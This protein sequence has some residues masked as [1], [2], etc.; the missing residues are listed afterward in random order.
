MKYVLTAACA[1]V[2]A[3]LIAPL[4]L[5][6]RPAP[7]PRTRF[8]EQ[9]ETFQHAA[10]VDARWKEKRGHAF[11]LHDREESVPEEDPRW[12]RIL[13]GRPVRRPLPG[14][15]LTCH[16][17]IGTAGSGGYYEA[18]GRKPL[19]CP[20]CH[21]PDT[22]ALRLTRA[23]PRAP[24]NYDELRTLVCA[25]CHREYSNTGFPQGGSAEAIEAYYER[26]GYFD[27]KHA[28]TGAVV[29]KAQHPQ[30]EMYGQG[31]HARAGVGCPDCHMPAERRGA[32]RIT[33]HNARSPLEHL[34]RSCLPCHRASVEEMRARVKAIEQRT[35]A[36]LARAED[37]LVEAIDAI[38]DAQAAGTRVDDALKL[39]TKAQWRIDF[40][41]A[42]RSK[43]FHAPQEAA[44][45]LAE[46]IDFARAAQLDAIKAGGRM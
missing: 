38:R 45:L 46:A 11:S 18:A 1:A 43:G 10:A 15:C 25:Q 31:I 5:R 40:V 24:A 28:E 17:A 36:L 14:S 19:G 3:F 30:F 34:D 32:L 13:A 9:T 35:A 44:R 33:D 41:A 7:K 26:S 6:E 4:F 27:W 29:I 37:S 42:D 20:D 2:L 12:N 23:A 39:Q 22:T 21:D 16:A 8:P